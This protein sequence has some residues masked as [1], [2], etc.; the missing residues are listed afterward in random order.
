VRIYPS[1][2]GKAAFVRLE[3]GSDL[4]ASLNEAAAELGLQAATLQVV[5][6]VEALK[7]AYYR[8]D[9]KEYEMHE[10]EAPHE[11]SGGVGNVSLKDGKPFV[12]IHVTGSGSD[13]RAVAGHL[14]E[15]TRV[16]LIEAYFRDLGG[17]APVREQE[18]DLGLAVWQ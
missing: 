11:I 18:D 17:P 15:G 6:A 5:G 12:H 16:F 7:V 14:V 3:R 8:Q 10:F 13:G 9:T 1:E 4:L 2:D